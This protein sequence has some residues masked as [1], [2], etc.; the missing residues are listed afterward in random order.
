MNSDGEVSSATFS[1][2]WR[3]SLHV[4]GA[5]A[6]GYVE[7]YYIMSPT[8]PKDSSMESTVLALLLDIRGGL[9]W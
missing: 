6:F 4:T 9:I 2:L 7:A 3:P 1:E 5:I 8:T